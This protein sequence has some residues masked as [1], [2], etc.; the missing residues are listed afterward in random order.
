[1][2]GFPSEIDVRGGAVHTRQADDRLVEDQESGGL[3]AGSRVGQASQ[4]DRGPP[5]CRAAPRRLG[6]G[7]GVVQQ[8][9]THGLS[10]GRVDV[11]PPRP[12][13]LPRA[14]QRQVRL[15][16]QRRRRERVPRP[17]AR[18]LPLRRVGRKGGEQEAR[19][20]RKFRTTW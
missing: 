3:F 5:G 15:V 17:L 13:N 7:S 2:F 10:R 4:V 6:P 18:E 14:H 9:Q 12:R 16:H 1:M 19:S 20:E 11:P 8:H